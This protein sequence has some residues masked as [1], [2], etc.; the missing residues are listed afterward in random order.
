MYP[1]LLIH[2]G[3]HG[4]RYIVS[5]NPIEESEAWLAMFM[6]IDLWDGYYGLGGDA[7][8]GDE[9]VWYSEAKMGDTQAA[10]NLLKA[11]CGCEYEEVFTE[12]IETPAT[13]MKRFQ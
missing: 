10:E 5:N 9:A 11:R 12:C 2:K 8:E 3:K 4:D 1:K 13:L 6:A 7:L